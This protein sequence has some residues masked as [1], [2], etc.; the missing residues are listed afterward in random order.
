MKVD[1][2]VTALAARFKLALYASAIAYFYSLAAPAAA[3]IQ[4]TQADL[5]ALSIEELL[6]VEVSTASRFVQ[7]ISEAP[8][9]VT[10]ITAADIKR[11]GHRTLSDVLASARGLFVSYDRS[12]QYLGV[13]GFNRPGDFNSRI[14]L[15]V[16]GY[17]VNDANYDTASTGQEFFL[18]VDL[19]D[20]VEVVRG[21]GSAI[22]G[23]NAFFAVV[24]VFT[25]HGREFGGTEVSG[26]VASYGGEKGRLVYGKQYGNGAEL[27][28]A[29]S[30]SDSGGQDLFF[31]E[32]DAPATGNGI[33]RNLD[34]ERT[35]RVYGKLGYGGYSLTAAYSE[36]IK[37]I[38][39]A[40]FGTAFNE[41]NMQNTD[42]QALLDLGYSGQL[43]ERQNIT[44]SLYYGGYFYEAVLPYDPPPVTLNLDEAQGEW[45]GTAAKLESRYGKHKL[46]TG[47]EYQENYRQ[48]LK[49]H[50][51]TP[52]ALYVEVKRNSHRSALYVQDE[53][54]LRDNLLLNAGLRYDQYS[55]V[56]AT[57]NPRLGFIYNP[58]P[59][60]A[61]KL[62]YGTAFRAPNNFEL[63]GAGAQSKNNPGL[64]PETITTYELVAEHE[65]QRNFRLT[66]SLYRNNIGNLINQVLDP[67]DG[68]LVFRN[69]G[70][71][72]S[73]GAEFEA[74]RAWDNEHRLRASYAW[75]ISR[76]QI[77]GAEL[78][79]SPRH[80]AKFNYT[81]PLAGEAL[82]A[83]AELQF[84]GNRKT[85]AGNSAG[86]FAVANL[87]LLAHEPVRGVELAAT[88]YN[89][90][91]RQ[92]AD[93]AR[94]EHVQDTIRQNGR[95]FRLKLDYRF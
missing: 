53:V 63:Y 6:A 15:L 32:F 84:T 62:L 74:E 42:S 12:Y 68:L 5:T 35:K 60:T 56:G 52:Y 95:N 87:T 77:T 89:L 37:Q 3:D 33:A 22:Y 76:D 1:F 29:A 48:D 61:I 30:A 25:K 69:I 92:Y 85:L 44:L 36:R 26:E 47:V 38:P 55:T 41:P 17:R 13:R 54:A 46:V 23:S 88:L 66:A 79:N 94:P 39:T 51:V 31:P 4:L 86:G 71:V 40:A 93:P 80:L 67:A 45:W 27:L 24:N 82:R 10:V 34:G 83:G 50:D 91:D 19:I 49:N 20:R 21:A 9:S 16:D 78:E 8:A 14:L 73:Q 28:F 11:Y 90:F 75:Q 57:A 58:Q 64:E 43:N 59:A 70:L 72:R 65:M 18:D 7:K 2:P 81:A